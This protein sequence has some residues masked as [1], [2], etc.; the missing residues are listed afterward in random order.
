MVTS[1]PA[2]ILTNFE[3]FLNPSEGADYEGEIS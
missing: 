1:L 3:V 2:T